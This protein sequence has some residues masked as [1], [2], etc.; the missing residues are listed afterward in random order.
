MKKYLKK[1]KWG[2]ILF[3]IVAIEESHPF[4]MSFP[5][6]T[7]GVLLSEKA[8]IIMIVAGL[9]C[10]I[11]GIFS[12][13]TNNELQEATICP[14]CQTPFGVGLGLGV[15]KDFQHEFCPQCKVK[16]EPLNG[17][18]KRHPEL[19]NAEINTSIEETKE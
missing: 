7:R 11:Y 1:F 15:K 4:S 12:Q 16:L 8:R 3:G 19:K 9:L 5:T 13:K 18:Y 2:P 14:K 17:F 10:I 6:Y